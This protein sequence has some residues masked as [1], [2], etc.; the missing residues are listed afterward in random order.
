MNA[1]IRS[2]SEEKD[3]RCCSSR[4]N[5]YLDTQHVEHGLADA[6]PVEWIG[7]LQDQHEQASCDV[8]ENDNEHTNPADG[9]KARNESF[10]DRAQTRKGLGEAKDAKEAEEAENDH[11]K[12][13]EDEAGG[14]HFNEPDANLRKIIDTCTTRQLMR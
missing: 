14:R 9:R 10:D 5:I 8:V 4:A 6:A 12:Q 2:V 3:V 11:W 13:V 1:N 7:L